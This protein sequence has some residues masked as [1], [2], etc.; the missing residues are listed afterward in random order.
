MTVQLFSV[1][2]VFGLECHPYDG[3]T[4]DERWAFILMSINPV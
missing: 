1:S 4:H 3:V 2:L